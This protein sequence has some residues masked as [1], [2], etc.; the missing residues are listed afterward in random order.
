MSR[1]FIRV[2]P[3]DVATF[4]PPAAI[5]CGWITWKARTRA[6]GWAA[7]YAQLAAD[8]GIPLRTVRR[9]CD[10]LRQAGRLAVRRASSNDATLVWSVTEVADLDT[11]EV[12]NV[13]R[14]GGRSGHL[15][16][17][18]NVDT[19]SYK[20]V[21][22]SRDTHAAVGDVPADPLEEPAVD[23][24]NAPGLFAV[25]DLPPEDEPQGP[26]KTA[27][28]LVARWCDGYRSTHAGK[29]APKAFMKRVAGQAR[30]LAKACGDNHDE[31]VGAYHAAYD[32]GTEAQADMTR[33]LVSRPTRSN[34]RRNVFADA[35]FG[36]PDAEA[37]QRFTAAVNGQQPPALESGR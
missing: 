6:D 8:T 28:T 16:E 3:E 26:P 33:F 7:S 12:S 35:A 24:P 18:A 36:G 10:A 34:A 14:G 29:D 9:S 17:S 13:D 37:M 19:S 30:N 2:T 1:T 25:P 5:V 27:R 15:P 11:P 21:E 20:T 22:T 31:W 23:D 4:G 32:A